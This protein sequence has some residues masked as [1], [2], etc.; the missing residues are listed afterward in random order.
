M[1]RNTNSMILNRVE[2]LQENQAFYDMMEKGIRENYKKYVI[3][4][5]IDDGYGIVK[6]TL[7]CSGLSE[8]KFYWKYMIFHYNN[9]NSKLIRYTQLVDFKLIYLK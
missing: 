7:N 8:I 5:G 4:A 3:E 1:G 2:D 9:G 6:L